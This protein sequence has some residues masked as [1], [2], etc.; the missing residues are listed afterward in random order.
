MESSNKLFKVLVLAGGRGKRLG[1]VTKK[2]NKCLLNFQGKPLIEYSLENAVRVGVI[3]IIIVVG[4]LA[5]NIINRYGNKFQ[6]HPIRYIV[7]QK[8]LGLV[9]AIETAK[10]AIGDSDFILMLGDEFF[11]NPYHND[12]IEEFKK[13]NAFAICG[14]VPVSNLSLISKTYSIKY[15]I[16]G[17]IFQLIEKPEQPDNHFMGTGNIIF[18]NE[19]LNYID[20]TPINKKRNERELPDLIQCAIDDG[21]EVY[22]YP[23]ASKYTNVNTAEDIL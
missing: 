17:R 14:V 23:F 19:I 2:E 21:K 18:R 15:D 9:H 22:Y 11:I 20:K 1:E 6:E 5:K 16:N 3:E 7:Q 8:Q 13:K 12:M 10:E 4:H